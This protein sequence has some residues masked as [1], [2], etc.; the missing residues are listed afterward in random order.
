MTDFAKQDR[1]QVA[2]SMT[3]PT[4]ELVWQALQLMRGLI[5]TA[6]GDADFTTPRQLA[7]GTW[8]ASGR[9]RPLQNGTPSSVSSASAEMGS[10]GAAWGASRPTSAASSSDTGSDGTA[11]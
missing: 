4:R 6:G 1:D 8:A 5:E 3:A 2:F 9:W 7:A 10:G 11:S